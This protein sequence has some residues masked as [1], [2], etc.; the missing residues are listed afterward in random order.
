MS[1]VG[2]SVRALV[3]VTLLGVTLFEVFVAS[4]EELF[5]KM[6]PEKVSTWVKKL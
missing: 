4:R 6:L 2:D 3:G 1:V 5:D